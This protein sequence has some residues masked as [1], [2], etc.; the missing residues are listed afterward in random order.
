MR[1]FV[2]PPK[3]TSDLWRSAVKRLPGISVHKFGS[4]KATET[5]DH[6]NWGERYQVKPWNRILNMN[7]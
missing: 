7:H 2:I 4:K 5:Y 6:S 3:A 1:T